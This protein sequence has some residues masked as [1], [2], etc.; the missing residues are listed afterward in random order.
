MTE[1]RLGHLG[2]QAPCLHVDLREVIGYGRGTGSLTDSE[3]LS[4]DCFD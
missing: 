2:T 3:K 4:K 1:D